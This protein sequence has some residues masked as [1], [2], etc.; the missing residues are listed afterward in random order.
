M[1]GPY[2]ST[3]LVV[4]PEMREV[5]RCDWCAWVRSEYRCVGPPH[6]VKVRREELNADGDCKFYRDSF[7][8]KVLRRFG[9]RSAALVRVLEPKP[10]APPS[11]RNGGMHDRGGH[12]GGGGLPRTGLRIGKRFD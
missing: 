7:M 12:V 3:S 6:A 8:T 9:L 5:V 10:E 4:I 1:S 2:R 11:P